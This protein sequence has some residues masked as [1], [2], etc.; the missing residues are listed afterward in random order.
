MVGINGR[1][2]REI[3]HQHV[4]T[5]STT[6]WI[7]IVTKTQNGIKFVVSH[8]KSES[9]F[10]TLGTGLLLFKQ[11]IK[12]ICLLA[13]KISHSP[14][15]NSTHPH[16]WGN[17]LWA[18]IMKYLDVARVLPCLYAFYDSVNLHSSGLQ[19]AIQVSKFWWQVKQIQN[20]IREHF[21]IVQHRL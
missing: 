5:P 3:V 21:R 14:Q 12:R 1:S 17:S 13:V 10:I 2:G 6:T 18:K 7:W 16:Q 4:Y 19:T 15:G 9:L 11:R 20:K 8:I